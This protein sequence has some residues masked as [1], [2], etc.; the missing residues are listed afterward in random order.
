MLLFVVQQTKITLI[1]ELKVVMIDLNIR[2]Y[3]CGFFTVTQNTNILTQF[4]NIVFYKLLPL[5]A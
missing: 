4:E 2:E 1:L 3:N 5:W